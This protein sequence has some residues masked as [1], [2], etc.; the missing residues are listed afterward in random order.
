MRVPLRHK[1]QLITVEIDRDGDRYRIDLDGVAQ[2]VDARYLDDA[3]LM[4]SIDGRPYRIDVARNGRE[5]LVAVGGEVYAFTMEPSAASSHTVAA[6]A[7]P[8][9]TAPMPGKILQVLVQPGDRVVAGDG[10]VILEA[11][12]METRLAAEAAGTVAEVRVQAGD[13]VDGGQVLIVLAYGE[14]TA[15]VA[16]P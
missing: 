2:T 6:V 16:T 8:E 5:R 12:K 1:Q 4:L 13:M 7:V 11:M 14:E 15:A 9:L 10:L 3:T